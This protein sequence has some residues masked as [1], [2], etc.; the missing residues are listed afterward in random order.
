[1]GHTHRSLLLSG[2]LYTLPGSAA[3]LA[4]LPAFEWE[5]AL[6]RAFFSLNCPKPPTNSLDDS[7]SHAFICL[8]EKGLRCLLV[9]RLTV[10]LEAL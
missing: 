8:L 5:A 1:M 7:C 3:V 9:D 2:V 10:A 6:H 4:D